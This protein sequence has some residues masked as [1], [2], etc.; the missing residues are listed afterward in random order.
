[1]QIVIEVWQ[2]GDLI[3]RGEFDSLKKAQD[4]YARFIGD[5]GCGVEVYVDGERLKT[6]QAWK[7]MHGWNGYEDFYYGC[8][9]RG[10][11]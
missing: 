4:A 9:R 6:L 5:D 7:M 2:M 11:K 8:R 3:A 1:M 10:G